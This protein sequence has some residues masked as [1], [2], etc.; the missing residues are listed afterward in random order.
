MS[1][2][3]T[4]RTIILGIVVVVVATV[5]ASAA[6]LIFAPDGADIA[7]LVGMVGPT[8]AALGAL[9]AARQVDAKVD[10]VEQTTEELAN[11]TMDAKIRAGIADVIPES[12]LDDTYR[13]QQL[14]ADRIRR[15]QRNAHHDEGAPEPGN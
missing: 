4:A 14:A 15:R 7:P 9:Y 12:I 5:L 3:G 8:V 13:R 6:V 11:G 10:R 2:N 1:N